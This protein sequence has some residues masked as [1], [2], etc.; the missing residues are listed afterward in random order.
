MVR[1]SKIA[2]R[3]RAAL[4]DDARTSEFGIEVI[5]NNGLVTLKGAVDS[6]E[7]SE[8][9]EQ[10]ARRQEGVVSVVNDVEVQAEEQGPVVPPVVPKGTRP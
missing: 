5:D 2:K 3:V 1:Y 10:I 7:T 9:A 4:A 8:V 6:E